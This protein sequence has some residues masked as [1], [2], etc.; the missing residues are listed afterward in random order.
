MHLDPNSCNISIGN[1]IFERIGYDCVNKYCKGIESLPYTLIFSSIYLFNPMSYPF[2][3][4]TMNYV[5][6]NSLSLKYQRFTASGLK[7]IRI[8]K[9]EFVTKTQFL[10]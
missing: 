4:Q 10:C 9:F 6:S 8:R 3:F 5:T 7:N 1:E 2:L